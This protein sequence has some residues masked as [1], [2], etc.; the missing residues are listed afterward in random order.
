MPA[1]TPDAQ[2]D[3]GREADRLEEEGDHEH[4]EARVADCVDRSGVEGDDT[5]QVGQEDPARLDEAHE[6]GPGKAAHRETALRTGQEVGAR[7]G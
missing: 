7:G 4:G 1:K 5:R 2:R 3:D 6:D